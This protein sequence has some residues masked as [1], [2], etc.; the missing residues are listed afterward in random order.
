MARLTYLLL[1]SRSA[2]VSNRFS[3]RLYRLYLLRHFSRSRVPVALWTKRQPGR[4]RNANTHT[5]CNNDKH[6]H[7]HQPPRT[8]GEW[9]E[10]GGRRRQPRAGDGWWWTASHLVI[11]G[12][13]SYGTVNATRGLSQPRTCIATTTIALRIVEQLPNP[14]RIIAANVQAHTHAPRIRPKAAR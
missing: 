6:H 5:A 11:K 1:D 2:C 9:C 14:A 7:R 12:S 13:M 8:M 10:G 3:N 4:T